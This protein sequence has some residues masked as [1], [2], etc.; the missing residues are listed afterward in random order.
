[1]PTILKH[2]NIEKY[3]WTEPGPRVF[4]I[5]HSFIRRLI[6]W[7]RRNKRQPLLPF[8]GEA[9]GEGGMQLFELIDIVSKT[10][11]DWRSFDSVFIQIGE[12]DIHNMSI[13]AMRAAM[14]TIHDILRSKRVRKIKFR[15]M[16]FFNTTE[17]STKRLNCTTRC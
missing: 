17:A 7:W 15:Q 16:F 10:D 13:K 3:L 8:H 12:N 5:G 9:Y 1:M 6:V 14:M 4:V 2:K 11:R